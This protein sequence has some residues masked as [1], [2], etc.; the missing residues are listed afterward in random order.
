MCP[1][2]RSPTKRFRR[3]SVWAKAMLTEP[4]SMRVWVLSEIEET[5]FRAMEDCTPGICSTRNAR[6]IRA[7]MP[8]SNHRT[9]LTTRPAIVGVF[10][11]LTRVP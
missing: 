4:T 2:R 11:S 8:A 3:T 7:S 5:A 9:I 10:R 6:M 1:P